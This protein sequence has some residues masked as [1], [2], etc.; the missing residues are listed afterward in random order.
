M[1][2]AIAQTERGWLSS[3]ASQEE[4]ADHIC[5]HATLQGD[6]GYINTFLDRLRQVTGA[7]VQQAAA[8]W[9]APRSRA[10]VAYIKQDGD[11]S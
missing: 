8:V 11:A 2:S 7:Q 6:S 9:L 10:V 5:H 1:E 3:L 4:R